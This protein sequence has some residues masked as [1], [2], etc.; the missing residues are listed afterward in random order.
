MQCQHKTSEDHILS[1]DKNGCRIWVCSSC[2]ESSIWTKDHSS[3]G[4]VECPKCENNRMDWVACSDI[5]A[6]KLKE[7]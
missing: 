1:R 2:H 5:C 7:E 3:F 4:Q 6:K